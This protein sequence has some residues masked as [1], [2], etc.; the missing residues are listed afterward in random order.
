MQPTNESIAL[1]INGALLA[2]APRSSPDELDRA[3]RGIALSDSPVLIRA[4]YDDD[5]TELARRLHALGR[6][7]E[8]PLH[9]CRSADEAQAL[10]RAIAGVSQAQTTALGTWALCG[11]T[12]WPKELQRSLTGVL[13]TFDESRL[14]GRL[15]HER[16]PRVIVLERMESE[17]A[18]EPDLERRLSFFHIAANLRPGPQAT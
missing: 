4:E 2:V 17:P 9:I 14:H 13:A 15:S 12:D 18:F 11:V 3:L 8:L 16:I 7:R 1:S 10:F 6:R 5:R